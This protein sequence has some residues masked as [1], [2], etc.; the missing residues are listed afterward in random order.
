MA[1]SKP[2]ETDLL[3]AGEAARLLGVSR[4]TLRRWAQAG[5]FRPDLR[6]PGGHGRY[7]RERVLA[8]LHRLA[9]SADAAYS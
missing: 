1:Q 2:G 5:I 7:R 6:T 3:S 4:Q 9:R 8:F